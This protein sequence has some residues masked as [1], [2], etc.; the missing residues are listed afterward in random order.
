MGQVD[1][2]MRRSPGVAIHWVVT[3]VA[4]MVMPAPRSSSVGQPTDSHG[5]EPIQVPD[6]DLAPIIQVRDL[7]RSA[8][9]DAHALLLVDEL[10][11]EFSANMRHCTSGQDH[12]IPP[13]R[14]VAPPG[15][16]APEYD[17]LYNS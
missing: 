10:P 2:A 7:A 12:D 8:G 14:D 3:L 11:D 1:D 13:D 15:T 17:P 4:W 6:H 9:E 5:S 16:T